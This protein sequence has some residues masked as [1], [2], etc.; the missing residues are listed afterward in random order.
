[1]L[2]TIFDIPMSC[3][4]SA[5]RFSGKSFLVKSLLNSKY[6]KDTFDE[7]YVFSS[8]AEL[9]E[10]W[11]SLKNPKVVLTSELNNDELQNILGS[12]EKEYTQTGTKK[13]ILIIVDDFIEK[14]NSSKENV[15]NKI[16]VKGRHFGINTIYC[17]QK[18]SAFPPI[19]RNNAMVKIVFKMNNKIEYSNS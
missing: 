7:I 11:N 19:M 12:L 17:S 8:T 1:M 6:F 13:Q 16:I 10:T 9:D 14:F 2:R 5:R 18:Y 3:I 15:L 4:V